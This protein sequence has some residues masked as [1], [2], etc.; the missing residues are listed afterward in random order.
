MTV[1][2]AVAVEEAL[3]QYH[4]IILE[5]DLFLGFLLR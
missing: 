1:F 5:A 2:V 4:N 3:K